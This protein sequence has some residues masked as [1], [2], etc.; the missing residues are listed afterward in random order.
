MLPNII[1]P[2]PQLNGARI[3]L[4]PLKVEDAPIFLEATQVDEI[5]HMTGLKRNFNL[6]EIEAHIRRCLDHPLRYDFA[7]CLQADHCMIGELSVLEIDPENL[8]A[9]FRIALSQIRFTSQ[10]YGAEAI[11]L[12]KI[13]VF[14]QLKLE[15]LGLEVFGHNPRGIRAYEKCGFQVMEVKKEAFEYQDKYS[16]EIM[17]QAR[18]PLYE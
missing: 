9:E 17:M 12:V 4:R 16:D 11:E 2:I 8:T 1:K 6:A 15:T 14:D 10:G 18:N 3:Y 5:R 7:I 13:F